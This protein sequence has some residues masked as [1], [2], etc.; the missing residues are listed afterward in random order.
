LGCPEVI[1][2]RGG[3][4]VAAQ[5]QRASKCRALRARHM[6]GVLLAASRLSVS[7]LYVRCPPAWKA[8]GRAANEN[9][10]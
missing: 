4:T 2:S 3:S 5:R 6:R 9:V 7:D 1:E 10:A 8:S